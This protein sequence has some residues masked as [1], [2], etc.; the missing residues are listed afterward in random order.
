MEEALN[1]QE[2]KRMA[3]P[4]GVSQTLLAIP[5]LK[6]LDVW[7]EVPWVS[8]QGLPLTKDDLAVATVKYPTLQQQT[9]TVMS[10][11]ATIHWGGQPATCTLKQAVIHIEWNW[12]IVQVWVYISYPQH[13]RRQWQPTP[14]FLPGEPHGQR[15]LAG[16]SLWAGKESDTTEATEY[17]PIAE[18]N[19]VPK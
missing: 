17:A 11:H 7:M 18:K 8:Q 9:L 3:W 15:S 1:N 12:H 5:V 6:K 2:V 4:V 14:V 19:M 16:Y 10:Q 13:R